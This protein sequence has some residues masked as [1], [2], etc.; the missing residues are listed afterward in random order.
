MSPDDL[1]K[2]RIDAIKAIRRVNAARDAAEE[3]AALVENL[4]AA[5]E[6]KNTEIGDLEDRIAGLEGKLQELEDKANE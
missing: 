6:V 2:S 5:V 3:L 4:V 1:T